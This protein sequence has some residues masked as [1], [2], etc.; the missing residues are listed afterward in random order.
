MF[1]LQKNPIAL[2][3]IFNILLDPEENI[4]YLMGLKAA[5]GMF[6]LDADRPKIKCEM[7]R[8]QGTGNSIIWKFQGRMITAGPTFVYKF[9]DP[10]PNN[11]SGI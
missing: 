4:G 2:L 6:D 10:E 9:H 3:I 7:N 5:A 8:L 1:L 11:E